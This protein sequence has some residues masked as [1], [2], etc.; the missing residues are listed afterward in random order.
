MRPQ[1]LAVI[2]GLMA[3]AFAGV[4]ALSLRLPRPAAQAP[5]QA[6]FLWFTNGMLGAA[7]SS[8]PAHYSSFVREWAASG[9]K[10]AVFGITNRQSRT[11]I[12]SPWIGCFD[13]TN[14]ARSRYE[15]LLLNAPTAYGVFLPPGRGAIVEVAVLP[16]KGPIRARLG[17]TPDYYH[18]LPRTI[19]Q[20]RGF[21]NRKPADFHSEW[22]YSDLVDP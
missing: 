9:S 14:A 5:M 16:Q 20:A 17:C 15:T 2:G 4:L 11:V 10:V 19:E 22:F 6:R 12:L 21:V 13:T 1:K 7:G 3:L 8:L 18:F